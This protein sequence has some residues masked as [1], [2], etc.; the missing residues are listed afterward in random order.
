[1]LVGCYHPEDI[2]GGKRVAMDIKSKSEGIYEKS[3]GLLTDRLMIAINEINYDDR[4]LEVGV[5]WGE[6]AQNIVKYKKVSL[7]AVDVSES[8]LNKIKEYV[9]QG[10]VADVSS[11]K[12]KFQDN[13]FDI[14]ICLETFEHLKNSYYALT[15]IQRVLKPKGKLIISIP[16]YLGGHLMIY[17]GLITPKSFR[18]FLRQ[19]GF[20]ISKFLM[21]GPVLNKDNI[22]KLIDS[23]LKNTASS[24][25]CLR[26]IQIAVRFAQIITKLLCL[27]VTALYWCYTF[28]CKNRKDLIDK[29]LWF[30]QLEQ[31]TELKENIGWYNRYYHK[32]V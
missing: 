19:N 31:T 22:G 24:L 17:P 13:Q 9:T 32:K 15:E 27:K 28:V 8:A 6:L 7:F 30:K 11:E 21:W 16:N 12:L 4:I 10:Q 26:L 20:K 3:G 2:E 18:L 1:M 14:V 23:K 5:G 25:F 29:P